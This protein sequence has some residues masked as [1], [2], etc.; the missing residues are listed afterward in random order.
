V[1]SRCNLAILIVWVAC[2]SEARSPVRRQIVDARTTEAVEPEVRDA[3]APV[4]IDATSE[5]IDATVEVVVDAAPVAT[6]PC[7]CFS[8]VHLD[9][10]GEFCYPT[11]ATCNAE[12]RSFARTDKLPCRVE[13]RTTCERIACVDIGA[14]CY[15]L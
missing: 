4:V 9:E 7:F 3:A 10:N 11:S 2:A 13:Q 6:R 8:W 12:F 1:K 14:R 5:V 15:R